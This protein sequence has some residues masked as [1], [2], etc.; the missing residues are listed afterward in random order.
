MRKGPS[1]AVKTIDPSR[2]P[3]EVS[4]RRKAPG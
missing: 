3:W 4:R 1:L 2:Q